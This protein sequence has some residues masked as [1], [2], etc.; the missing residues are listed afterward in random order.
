MQ[1]HQYNRYCIL[2]YLFCTLYI[3]RVY[4]NLSMNVLYAV[5]RKGNTYTE[6]GARYFAVVCSCGS[7]PLLLTGSFDSSQIHSP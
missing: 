5:Y 1:L 6:R 4:I 7:N 3:N 2:K